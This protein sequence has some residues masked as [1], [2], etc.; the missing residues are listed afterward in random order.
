MNRFAALT[1]LLFLASCAP[2]PAPVETAAPTPEH[3]SAA[4]TWT[5]SAAPPSVVPT[6]DLVP[7]STPIPC[8]PYA[9][10]FC[11]T[12]GSFLF[13]RPILPPA[14]NGVDISYRYGTTVRRKRDPHHGVEFLNSPGTPV[15]AAGDGQVVF[16][17]PDEVAIYSPWHLFYGNMVVIRHADDF[18]TLYAHLSR[19]D[20]VSG[21]MVLAGEK[22]GEVGQTGAATGSHLHFE[23][24]RGADY[25]STENP[26]LWLIPKEGTGTISITLASQRTTKLEREMVITGPM[27]RVYYVVTYAKGFEHNDEDLAITDLPPGM[28]R[29]AFVE[30]GRFFNR[31]VEVQA[32]KLT[33][34]VFVMSR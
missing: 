27:S 18:Y 12:D 11:I 22:I 21:Q 23:V 32:G 28:Y 5:P 2:A 30:S 24:R 16:A 8:N 4:S 7:A 31:E 10:D 29:I 15:F 26:E 13:Q 20:V 9:A 3:P 34:V 6:E 19:V 17:G 33:E 14:N 1:L 25:F